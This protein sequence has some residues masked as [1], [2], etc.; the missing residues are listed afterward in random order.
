MSALS[1]R[2]GAALAAAAMLWIPTLVS[3]AGAAPVVLSALA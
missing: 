3:P 1:L 2:L